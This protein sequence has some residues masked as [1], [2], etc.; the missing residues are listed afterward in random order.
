MSAV[1][2]REVKRW[3][4][5]EYHGYSQNVSSCKHIA[6]RCLENY[7]NVHKAT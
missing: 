4:K 6:E 5:W 2:T 3:Y 7:I 1:Y